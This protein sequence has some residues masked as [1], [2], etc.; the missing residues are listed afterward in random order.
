[1][2]TSTGK[3]WNLQDAF[4]HGGWGEDGRWGIFLLESVEKMEHFFLWCSL[5]YLRLGQTFMKS[6]SSPKGEQ[7]LNKITSDI[8][9]NKVR[10]HHIAHINLPVAITPVE[11]LDLNFTE[12]LRRC[13]V[14][15]LHQK[16]KRP[17]GDCYIPLL[18]WRSPWNPCLRKS[19]W[20]WSWCI[21]MMVSKQQVKN[22]HI[23]DS[24]SQIL[25]IVA[26][27]CSGKACLSSAEWC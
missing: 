1:M 9:S 2:W 7:N 22:T 5:S 23:F 8:R 19:W 4:D 12:I 14:P 27:W 21:L 20:P 3:C 24:V 13:Q 6:Q 15:T 16:W 18:C 26:K 17:R 25:V 11:W 10:Y